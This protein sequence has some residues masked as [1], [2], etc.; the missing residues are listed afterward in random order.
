MGKNLIVLTLLLT[1]ASFSLSHNSGSPDD[2]FTDKVDSLFAPLSK[3][4]T[5][6]AAVIVIKDGQIL[7]KK[8]YG[9]ANLESKKPIESDTA[10]LLGSVTK[11]FTAMAIMM[12]AERGQL[13]Y[14]DSLAKFF[15][16]FPSYAQK[17]T[18]RHLLHHL[19]GFPEYDDLFI[20]SGK[21]DKNFPRSA[22]SKPSSFE[23]TAKDALAILAQVSRV[24]VIGP[25]RIVVPVPSV[26]NM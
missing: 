22:K 18:V 25:D 24:V 8:G 15:P 17:I 23:P 19:A 21:L 3:G 11:S 14:T 26:P 16:Q 12:L 5:P 2:G 20:E 4:D 13:Q 10:F 9:L 1:L 6:G 7:L